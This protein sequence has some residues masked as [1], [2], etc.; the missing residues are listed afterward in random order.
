MNA[1]M[2]V[3]KADLEA[4]ESQ[5]AQIYQKLAAYSTPLTDPEKTIVVGYFLHNLYTALEYLC[6]VVAETFEIKLMI[7]ASGMPCS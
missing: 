6:V 1:K 4:D 2:Q 5:I 7:V 3:L